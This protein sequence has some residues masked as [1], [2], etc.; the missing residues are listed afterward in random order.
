[1]RGRKGIAISPRVALEPVGVDEHDAIARQGPAHRAGNDRLSGR[2]ADHHGGLGLPVGIAQA[3]APGSPHLLDDLRIDRLARRVD[4][5]QHDLPLPEIMLDQHPPDGRRRAEHGDLMLDQRIERRARLEA[6]RERDDG[7]AGVPGREKARPGVLRPAGRGNVEMRVA[8]PDPEPVHR[9]EMPDRIARMGVHH[10]LRARRRARGEIEEHRVVGLGRAVGREDFA[11]EKR[12][13]G[14][15]AGRRL[16]D[17]DALDAVGKAGEFLRIGAMRDQIF[18]L[19]PLDPV[20]DVG[21]AQASASP[22]SARGRAS[23]TRASSPTIRERRPASSEDDRRAWRRARAGRWR[24]AT[25]RGQAR[26]R[27][28]SR[29]ARR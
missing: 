18:R 19:A 17:R 7:R 20:G 9:R 15:P 27:S 16:A 2:I 22:G 25:T 14:A 6:Q 24:A 23:S 13:V 12:V 1:M 8:G 3:Q 29:R 26:R 28:A 21:L 4:L 10:E 5:A 11:A